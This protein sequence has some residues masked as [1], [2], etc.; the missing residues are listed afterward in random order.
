M[1]TPSRNIRLALLALLMLAAAVLSACA[2][3]ASGGIT[4]AETYLQP[5][6][7]GNY[8]EAYAMLSDYDKQNISEDLYLRWR[9]AVAKVITIKSAEVNKSVDKFPD[10][11]YQGTEIGYALGLKISREQETKL[12]GIE[13]DGYNQPNYRQMVVYENEQWK[14]LLLLSELEVTVAGYEAF[15]KPADR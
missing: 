5:L 11:K 14:M 1:R 6:I 15:L 12:S 2:P 7:D 13:L 8:Q 10:Y 4:C 9:E 3:A